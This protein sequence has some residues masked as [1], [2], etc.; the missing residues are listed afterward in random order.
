MTHKKLKQNVSSKEINSFDLWLWYTGRGSVPEPLESK[1]VIGHR[2]VAL[3]LCRFAAS[4]V[5]HYY[6][7]RFAL[8]S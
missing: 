3:P 4:C 5:S 7:L 1:T 2:V 6:R 8:N